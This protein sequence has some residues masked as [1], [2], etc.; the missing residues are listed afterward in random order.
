MEE[1][2]SQTD[3]ERMKTHEEQMD[4]TIP[5]VVETQSPTHSSH[6][7]EIVLDQF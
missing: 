5:G 4:I 7:V 1:K 2:N 3:R 6:D